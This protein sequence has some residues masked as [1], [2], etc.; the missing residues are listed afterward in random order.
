MGVKSWAL[1]RAMGRLRIT[2]DIV[3]YLTTFQRLGETV[4]VELPS[5]LLPVGARTVFRAVRTRAAAQLGV[6]WV[7]PHWL[8]RQLDPRS[9]AFVPRGHLP[10]LTNVTLRNWTAVGTVASTRKGIVDPHGLLTPWYDGWSLDWWIGAEDRWH[11][12]SRETAVRQSA[13]EDTPVVETVMRVPGG[14]AAQRVYAVPGEDPLAVVEI[15]NRSRVPF[16]VALAVRP[17]NPEGLAI[18]ERITLHDRCVSVDG[19]P[20]LF[21]PKS[22]SAAVGSTFHHGDCA[23]LVMSGRTGDEFPRDLRCDAG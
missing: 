6:D 8:E 16:A 13:V 7:W 2:D 5:E 21:L 4:E 20:A 17:Y 18:V 3:R 11:F 22:P 10:V 15:T 9:A 1:R 19:R 23:G 14:D 12:P